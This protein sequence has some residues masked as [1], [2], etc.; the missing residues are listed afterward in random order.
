[1]TP[2]VA[3]PDVSTG[4]QAHIAGVG[5]TVQKTAATGGTET[6]GATGGAQPP[7]AP[8]T[9]G[10]SGL[11]KQ[12]TKLSVSGLR[13]T[14]TSL[15]NARRHGIPVSFRVPAGT[16]IVRVELLRGKTRLV[17]K[18][19]A[20]RSAGGRQTVLLHS[21]R[22]RAGTYRIRVWIGASRSTLGPTKMANIRI[23]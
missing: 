4:A 6:P 16:R 12:S 20:G 18:T 15:N 2:V 22:L 14:G 17:T 13:V 1:V 19:V 23:H 5:V 9:A 7:S 11:G 8:G 21:G 3:V 10:G